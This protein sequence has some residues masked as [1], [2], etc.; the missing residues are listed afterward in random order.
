M[1]QLNRQQAEQRGK[2]KK[3]VTR[4]GNH[5]GNFSESLEILSAVESQSWFF[6]FLGY[7]FLNS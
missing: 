5:R 2:N 7:R 3:K 6:F 1:R 4:D